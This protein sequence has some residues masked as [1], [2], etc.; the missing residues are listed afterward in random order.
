PFYSTVTGTQVDTTTLDAEYW[1]TN[2]RQEVRFDE[3]VRALLADGFGYFVESSPH[4]VLAVGLAETFEDAGSDAVALGTLRRDEGGQERFLTSL[5]EGW[6]RGLPVDWHAVFAGTPARHVDL[7][8]YAFQHRRYWLEADAAR[9]GDPSGLGQEPVDHPLLSAAVR[10]AGEDRVVLTGRLAARTH[11]W[12]ADHT[13]HGRAVLPG[14][15]FAELA[16][17]AGESVG[18][19]RIE[20]LELTAP[21]ALP[22]KGA[23]HLQVSV[24]APGADGGRPLAVHARTE[25]AEQDAPWV[26]HATGILVPDDAAGPDGAAE[27]GSAW[28]P[29][30]AQPVSL[31]YFHR[32]MAD[33]GQVYGP[34]FEGLRKLWRVGREYYAEIQLPEEQTRDAARFCVHPAL[35]DAALQPA[36]VNRN[37]NAQWTRWSGLSLRATGA[38]ALRVHLRPTGQPDETTATFTDPDG[39]LVAV[40]D[41]AVPRP[42]TA[43]EV[44]RTA[45]GRS[46]SLHRVEWAPVPVPGQSADWLLL[47]PVADQLV[48]ALEESGAYPQAYE[49]LAALTEALDAGLPA[50][51][52]VAV[53]HGFDPAAPDTAAAARAATAE[54]LATVQSWLAED[55]LAPSRLVV[56][57]RHAVAARTE[58][59]IDDLAG[60]ALW[61]LIRSA[62]AA[63]PGRFVLVD[64]DDDPGSLALFP[65]SVP[66]AVSS[67]EP[68]LA[69][70]GGTVMVPRLARDASSA[71][72]GGTPWRPDGTVLITGGTGALGS[73]MARHL[74]QRHGVRHL[75]L[76][77]RRGEDGPGATELRAELARSGAATVTVAACDAADR[78]A[79]AAVLAAVPGDRPLTAVLHCAGVLS[80][81]PLERLTA[82]DVDRVF[83][84]KVDAAVNL[85]ELT[86]DAGLSS[87]V[88]FSSASGVLGSIAQAN[89]AAANAFL[90]ALARHRSDLGL[91]GQALAWGLWAQSSEMGADADAAKVARAGILPLSTSQG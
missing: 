72:A 30:G 61:G 75:L 25:D 3:T 24:G 91:P 71:T 46:D 28:P 20:E 80:D 6:V 33:L 65:T 12:L 57:T 29:R 67:G 69:L 60:A 59:R 52:L 37:L 54:L 26:R 62:Q 38:T 66:A 21:L 19:G 43:D 47:G 73:L 14:T 85:H 34:A 2:L 48:E 74:V 77:S 16:L 23:V 68:Q 90:D 32:R 78:D 4:S 35:L 64:V 79:L 31:A 42:V 44:S 10:V 53:S 17:Y 84:P 87:F 39:G 76:L 63:H 51:E 18:C 5:A 82:Q 83:A 40:L 13:L 7:P 88:L 58:D 55:R 15:V 36:L 49:D 70:R 89:Y 27:P 81:A 1:V 45:A 22:G 56:L 9:A 50:P 8:T 11:P 86:R 41:A